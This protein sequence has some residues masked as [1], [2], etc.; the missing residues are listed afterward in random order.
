[1]T[2]GQETDYPWKE[3]VRFTIGSDAP[4]TFTLALRVPG[5]CRGARVEV[6]GRPVSLA[7]IAKKGYAQV[8]LRD[9]ADE[10]G[11]IDRNDPPR[12]TRFPITAIAVPQRPRP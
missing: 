1:M 9:I 7:P 2:V 8:S 12:K 3:T 4:A 6:N 11:V 5:W 10:A